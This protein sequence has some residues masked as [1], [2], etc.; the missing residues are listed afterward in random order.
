[1][2]SVWNRSNSLSSQVLFHRYKVTAPENPQTAEGLFEKVERFG[3][4]PER[5]QIA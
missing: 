5:S 1:M 4:A 2:R 3:A